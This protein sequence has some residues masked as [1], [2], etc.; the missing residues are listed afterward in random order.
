[1]KNI[2][3]VGIIT[4]QSGNNYGAVYQSY[5]LSNYLKSLGF[6]VF[7]LNYQMEKPSLKKC[8]K[9]PISLIRKI[10]SRKAFTFNFLRKRGQHYK[11]VR[12]EEK[13]SEIFNEFRESYLNITDVF[14]DYKLLLKNPPAADFYITGSDQVW[15]ADFLFSSPAYLLG[16]APAYAKRISYAPS[17]GKSSLEPYLEKTF[18]NYIKRFDA[19]SVRESGG[20]KIVKNIAGI[21][22]V[23]VLDP[24]LLI[25]NYSEIIDY[26]LV[27]DAPYILL[28]RL[29]QDFELATWFNEAVE[30]LSRL[31]GLP[32]FTVATN[33]PWDLN[34][35]GTALHPT[36]GQLLGL[37]ER[38]STFLTNSFHGTV[39][40]LIFCVKFLSFARDIFKDKQNL[41]MIELLDLVDLNDLFCQPFS[42][43]SSIVKKLDVQIDW[44]GVH[45]AL[46]DARHSSELF[47]QNALAINNPN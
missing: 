39:F 4:L 25:S 21:D 20:V 10:I 15:A 13:F 35:S 43:D 18:K 28:Y 42:E 23:K 37:I 41:R 6:E 19:V 9:H 44:D 34:S 29:N 31:T 24:T 16:F 11:G 7:I 17:F 33:C 3:R 38:S 32:I 2:K 8:M 45:S 5:A 47:L 1:M 27:P 36:P 30:K 22:A 40:S 26:S 46:K 14:Y 12:R